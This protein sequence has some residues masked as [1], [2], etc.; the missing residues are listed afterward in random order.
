MFGVWGVDCGSGRMERGAKL[1][2]A[3]YARTSCERTPSVRQH[4]QP[5]WSGRDRST[6]GSCV[7]QASRHRASTAR[8]RVNHGHTG[9]Q[10]VRW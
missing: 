8:S 5:F 3:T 7:H 10:T 2:A 1:M 9:R 6:Q 4:W